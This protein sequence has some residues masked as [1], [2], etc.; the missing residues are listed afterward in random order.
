MHIQKKQYIN[1]RGNNNL[2]QSIEFKVQLLQTGLNGLFTTAYNKTWAR[3]S[4]STGLQ[5][6]HKE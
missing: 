3:Q 4:V 2:N 5:W 1:N 6:V